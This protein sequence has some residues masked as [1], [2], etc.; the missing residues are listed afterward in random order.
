MIEYLY[1]A[2]ILKDATDTMGYDNTLE[3][4]N[5]LDFEANYK[6]LCVKVDDIEPGATTADIVKTYAQF[7]AL[8]TG[9]L[10]WADVKYANEG[11]LY[12]LYLITDTPL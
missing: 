10:T 9:D 5:E 7:K 4:A 12:D 1:H 2:Y 11:K 6:N 8:I 3:H